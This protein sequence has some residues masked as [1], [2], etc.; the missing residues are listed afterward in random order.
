MSRFDLAFIYWL[1]NVLMFIAGLLVGRGTD[2]RL[3]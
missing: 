3:D 2:G 1:S